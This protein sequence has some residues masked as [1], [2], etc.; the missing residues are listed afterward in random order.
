MGCNGE[1][2][3]L[4]LEFTKLKLKLNIIPVSF[5]RILRGVGF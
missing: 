5:F 4:V 2:I 3:V 1:E